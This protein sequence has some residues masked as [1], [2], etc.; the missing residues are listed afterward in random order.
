ME[1]KEIISKR[2]KLEAE[3]LYILKKFENET[4]LLIKEIDLS[5]IE[6][7]DRKQQLIAVKVNID[8]NA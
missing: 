1:L 6:M 2:D 8:L 7:E 5:H 3:I 4:T